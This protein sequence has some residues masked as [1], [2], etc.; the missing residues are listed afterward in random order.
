M[1]SRAKLA[2]LQIKFDAL[3][4]IVGIDQQ[5][6]IVS[7]RD[8][9]PDIKVDRGWHHQ[10]LVVIRVFADQVHAS[11]GTVNPRSRAIMLAKFVLQFRGD[12]ARSPLLSRCSLQHLF[13]RCLAVGRLACSCFWRVLR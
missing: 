5:S 1:L 3:G 12:R 11:W 9:S 6:A 8:T 4:K 2:L 7:S 10:A 13:R